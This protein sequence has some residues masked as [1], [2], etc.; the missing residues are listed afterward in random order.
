MQKGYLKNGEVHRTSESHRDRQLYKSGRAAGLYVARPQSD[1]CVLRTRVIHQNFVPISLWNTPDAGGRTAVS[2]HSK[3]SIAIRS[4]APHSGRNSRTGL[5][6]CADRDGFQRVVP[7]A[8]GGHSFILA[9]TFEYSNCAASGRLHYHPGVGADRSRRF[10][11][12]QSECRKRHGNDNNQ[13]RRISR[14]AAE[15]SSAG[16]EKVTGT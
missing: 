6:Y 14:G 5:R 15:A 12:C 9:R 16:Q 4:H 11:F 1:G 10:W 3:L 13:I 2:G 8:A 7:L